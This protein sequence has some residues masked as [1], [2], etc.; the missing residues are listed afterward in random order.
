LTVIVPLA[1]PVAVGANA[2][3]MVQDAPPATEEQLSVSL[4]FALG[5]TVKLIVAALLLVTVKV[6]AT[7]VD[8]TP[9]LPNERDAGVMVTGATPVPVRLAVCVPGTALSLTVR[10]PVR[11]PVTVGLKKIEITQFPRAAT[12]LPQVLVCE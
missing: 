7:L 8:P 11:E 10:V 12:E 3:L 9:R 5:T 1:A 2:A 6:L 4:K